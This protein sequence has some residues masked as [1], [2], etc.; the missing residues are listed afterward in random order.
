MGVVVF[1]HPL[2]PYGQKVKI[3]LREKG[4]AFEAV[5][6]QAI[7]SGTAL[8]DFAAASPR[9]EVPALVDEDGFRVFDST[10]ILEYIEDRWPEPPL[11]PASPRERARVRMLEDA[12]DTH[13][14]AITWG[15]AELAFF[16]RAEGELA[17][18]MRAQAA[19][20]L[21]GWFRWLSAQL[22]ERRWF[23]GEAFGWGDLSVAPF[24]NGAAGFGHRPDGR[25]GEW[26]AR[27]NE[28][29][30]VAEFAQAA[31][32]AGLAGS[33]IGLE[34]VRAALDQ[35]LFKRE[36]RDHRLEWMVK[37]G[38]LEIVAEGLRKRNLRFVDPFA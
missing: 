13:F 17:E 20:Q 28:R 6:P 11:R 27:V 31:A 3:A 7:G 32:K 12:M 2:S 24:L 16:G 5:L 25:L 4:V 22:G 33:A 10:V 26:L 14:E 18:S 19:R 15:L 8:G 35:G 37:S 38:G 36:Y 21:A 30:S 29:P 1:D 34:Q 23:N 9:G